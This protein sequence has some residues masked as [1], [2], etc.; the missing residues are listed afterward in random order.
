MDIYDLFL[1]YVAQRNKKKTTKLF[2]EDKES[3]EIQSFEN[4]FHCTKDWQYIS[5]TG[6][7]V[8]V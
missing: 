7:L 6:M 4:N 8:D 2:K 1:L 3:G 5:C